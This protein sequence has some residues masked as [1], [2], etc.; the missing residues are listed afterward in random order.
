MGKRRY[1]YW[2]YLIFF[3]VAKW[4]TKLSYF[5]QLFSSSRS[6]QEINLYKNIKKKFIMKSANQ[7]K[8][9]RILLFIQKHAPKHCRQN[10]LFSLNFLCCYCCNC[11]CYSFLLFSILF[12]NLI[13]VHQNTYEIKITDQTSN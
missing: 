4:S 9:K 2:F 1:G 11:D 10:L 13:R 8:N 12:T 5:L 3:V 6:K 7:K